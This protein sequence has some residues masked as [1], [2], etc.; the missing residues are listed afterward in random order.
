MNMCDER[1]SAEK[2]VL[3][4][5]SKAANRLNKLQENNN[6]ELEIKL[7]VIA[8]SVCYL[9]CLIPLFQMDEEQSKKVMVII[10]ELSL[11]RETFEGLR[12]L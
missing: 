9:G 1:I 7:Q 8:N 3:T 4:L 2:E 6:E 10:S 5:T 12:H 11:V